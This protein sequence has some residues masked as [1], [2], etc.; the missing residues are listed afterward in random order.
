MIVWQT[1][2]LYHKVHSAGWG[3]V[4]CTH[5]DWRE[6]P[7]LLIPLALLHDIS[8]KDIPLLVKPSLVPCLF[9]VHAPFDSFIPELLSIFSPL[10][11]FFGLISSLVFPFLNFSPS[12]LFLPP[13]CPPSCPTN[14]AVFGFF[15]RGWSLCVGGWRGLRLSPWRFTQTVHSPERGG[16]WECVRTV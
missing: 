13:D 6:Q 2:R 12:S 4:W 14:M 10:P 15:G 16:W 9:S 1:Y 3:N 11:L 8:G 7:P 5:C